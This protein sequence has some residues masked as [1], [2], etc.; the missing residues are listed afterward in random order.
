MDGIECNR[1]NKDGNTGPS[2]SCNKIGQ[3]VT[4]RRWDTAVFS[5][6]NIQ[7]YNC[8]YYVFNNHLF[9]ISFYNGKRDVTP[10]FDYH[11]ELNLYIS[12]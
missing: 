4:I 6:C 9:K 5:V 8:E 10:K 7:V 12:L 11:N 3:E 1:Y 2:Y